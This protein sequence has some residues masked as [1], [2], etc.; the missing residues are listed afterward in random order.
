MN[1]GQ[2]STGG[3]D[4]WQFI[5]DHGFFV[6]FECDIASGNIGEIRGNVPGDTFPC[7]N[8]ADLPFYPPATCREIFQFLSTLLPA[9]EDLKVEFTTRVEGNGSNIIHNVYLSHADARTCAFHLCLMH[10]FDEELSKLVHV[11]RLVPGT[12]EYATKLV[13]SSFMQEVIF[14]SSEY[15]VLRFLV[16]GYTSVQIA[17]I[18]DLSPFFVDDLR[19]KLLH[20]FNASNIYQLIRHAREKK[21]I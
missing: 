12:G 10:H 16:Q 14:R 18:L 9:D 3:F 11:S 15:D 4:A 2:E 13:A 20:K 19:K 8:I 21:V 7:R 1:K 17:E 6:D 5:Y